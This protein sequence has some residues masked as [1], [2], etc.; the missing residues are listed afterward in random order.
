M[1]LAFFIIWLV[2]SVI[3][4]N[5]LLAKLFVFDKNII[6]V[7]AVFLPIVILGP[8]LNIFS[9]WFKLNDLAIYLSLAISLA[10]L[11]LADKYCSKDN[12]D[13]DYPLEENDSGKLFVFNDWL[14]LIFAALAVIGIYFV[15]HAAGLNNILS[16]WDILS[17]WQA[18][19]AMLLAGMIIFGIYSRKI[20][21]LATL[22]L[23]VIFSFLIHS[24]LFVYK[25]GF[26]GDRFRHLAS[27]ERILQGLEYQPTLL[28]EKMWLNKLGPISYPQALTDSAKLSYG[29]MW[30]LEV[31]AAKISGW[32]VFQINRFLLPI[33]WPIFLTVIIFAI[34][35][36]LRPDNRFALLAA[37]LAN[38]FYL[39]QYYGAQGLPASYGLLWLAFYLL[40]LINYLIKPDRLKARL[41]FAGL[42]LMYFNYSLAFLLAGCGFA[43]SLLLAKQK[44]WAYL[45]TI[46]AVISLIALDFQSSP[47]IGFLYAKLWPS[48]I[49]ANIVDFQALSRL[50]PMIGEWH[51]LE[52]ALMAGLFA[53]LI[54][55][56]IKVWRKQDLPWLLVLLMAKITLAAYF[57]S[58][59]F[60]NGEHSLSRRIMLFAVMFL[61]FF[62]ADFACDRIRSR[63]SF[64]VVASLIIF[65]T[66]LTYYSG[67]ALNVN[68]TDRDLSKAEAIWKDIKGNKDYCVKDD[69]GVILALEYVS[70]KEFQETVNNQNCKLRF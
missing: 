42:I 55:G 48:W 36:L 40:F 32:P 10:G 57:I 26:G 58:Y 29:T 56:F 64:I 51:L 9:A 27:E 68:V 47:Q 19:I 49:Y 61:L 8:V 39:L 65:L 1:M 13:N 62:L 44:F 67:P 6:M 5:R 11:F 45:A 20:S 14:Y 41:I 66:G 70:A 31:L 12:P 33:L 60:L 21:V 59:L 18:I 35:Y 3:I 16:P 37:L 23:I 34:A 15:T 30:S 54:I 63:N 24:Y 4:A 38:S 69:L 43:I 17:G 46:L 52:L 7:L 53:I 25:N 50:V 2:A 28:A 22:F